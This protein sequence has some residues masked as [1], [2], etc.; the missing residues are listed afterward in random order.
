MNK[1]TVSDF[2]DFLTHVTQP[3]NPGTESTRLRNGRPTDARNALRQ[4]PP[5]L[6]AAPNLGGRAGIS[7]FY[8]ICIT[9]HDTSVSV[10]ISVKE[11]QTPKS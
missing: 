6:H 5:A 11:F 7:E 8:L 2:D 1:Y 9:L 3:T 10:K 4:V